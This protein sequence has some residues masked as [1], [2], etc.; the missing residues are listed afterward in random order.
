MARINF[1][2]NTHLLGTSRMATVG[3]TD[4]FVTTGGPIVSTDLG[5]VPGLR[6][7]R[8]IQAIEAF[9]STTSLG[10]GTWTMP[11]DFAHVHADV[12]R[13]SFYIY[14]NTAG[15]P[16]FQ[17]TKRN[18]NGSAFTTIG[19]TSTQDVGG[20]YSATGTWVRVSQLIYVDGS[21]TL[22]NNSIRVIPLMEYGANVA[23]GTIVRVAG[24]QIERV[25]T[26]YVNLDLADPEPGPYFSVF[27]PAT[28]FE[29]YDNGAAKGGGNIHQNPLLHD[30][31]VT[32]AANGGATYTTSFVDDGT[33]G[34]ATTL[35]YQQLVLTARSGV[36]EIT[37]KAEVSTSDNPKVTAGRAYIFSAYAYSSQT[38]NVAIR[39]VWYN[40][41]G[42]QVAT[43]SWTGFSLTANTWQRAGVVTTAPSTATRVNMHIAFPS[44]ADNSLPATMRVGGYKIEEGSLADASSPMQSFTR[45]PRA[46][47]LLSA[48]NSGVG[49]PTDEVITADN[50]RN[51]GRPFDDIIS[52]SF[53][54]QSYPR[55]SYVSPAYP[56]GSTQ[57]IKFGGNSRVVWR[58]V[59]WEQVFVY[60]R[61]MIPSV[62]SGQEID[63]V[64][65]ISHDAVP[66]Q[67]LRVSITGDGHLRVFGLND[68]Q[69]Y[70]GSSANPVQSGAWYDLYIQAM[71]DKDPTTVTVSIS[72]P[73]SNATYEQFVP[74]V[75]GE[76]PT[77]AASSSITRIGH[78]ALG[79]YYN[80]ASVK[81]FYLA[82]MSARGDV[83]DTDFG[84][85]PSISRTTGSLEVA[86]RDEG[87]D[88]TT[89][90]KLSLVSLR[91]PDL[92]VEA[93]PANVVLPTITGHALLTVVFTGEM[94]ESTGG[95]PDDFTITLNGGGITPV[96]WSDASYMYD[97]PPGYPGQG[98]HDP[99][100]E[101]GGNQWSTY[102]DQV[103]M[104]RLA[105]LVSSAN[106]GQTL[107]ITRTDSGIT[108]VNVQVAI[109]H[110][111]ANGAVL[112]YDNFP[113]VTVYHGKPVTFPIERNQGIYTPLAQGKYG[114]VEM[115]HLLVDGRKDWDYPDPVVLSPNPA[116]EP[117]GMVPRSTITGDA[118]A[119]GTEFYEA[120]TTNAFADSYVMT[121]AYATTRGVYN[122]GGDDDWRAPFP[123]SV[124]WFSRGILWWSVWTLAVPVSGFAQANL[125]A[126]VSMT[127]LAKGYQA[128]FPNLHLSVGLYGG[129]GQTI[130]R[131]GDIGPTVGLTGRVEVK[132]TGSIAPTIGLTGERAI[133][134]P[135][136]LYT[137]PTG[138]LH[139]DGVLPVDVV[140]MGT[141]PFVTMTGAIG[142]SVG[143]V[144][145]V[146]EPLYPPDP[147]RLTLEPI[148]DYLTL[149]PIDPMTGNTL[150]P[151]GEPLTFEPLIDWRQ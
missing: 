86:V 30:G 33:T 135:L 78:V 88:T 84:V 146:P 79:N 53:N 149:E 22:E 64:T 34:P 60:T 106:S 68:V 136:Y 126:T 29:S 129:V 139:L 104:L 81:E 46:V 93:S 144:G 6:G 57:P 141:V 116:Q 61:F 123:D 7:Y 54:G 65:L 85:L 25:P 69:H 98:S 17:V 21:D 130:S 26:G 32:W 48:F 72:D 52:N 15:Q 10:V 19:F 66:Y 99:T 47:D 16:R 1:A 109:V 97:Y 13:F 20:F 151:I 92:T 133:Q 8:H 80:T 59:G 103:G 145:K 42:A 148:V 11:W 143:L 128:Y 51:S 113:D 137:G 44:V 83:L 95:V 142:H 70:I 24:M 39:L 121:R 108:G 40:D 31:L 76:V 43:Q 71:A 132:L 3:E 27:T 91:G 112:A 127:G 9:T 124:P 100:T 110:G 73:A 125:A 82:E 94:F 102:G 12:Y 23:N 28:T 140:A 58:S 101:G 49:A 63:L 75:D 62:G 77:V 18:W 74:W 114:L 45:L 14:S 35:P 150:E 87:T 131:S 55:W 105:Y 118:T 41:A 90:A 147:D 38:E 107:A 122:P 117:Y 138:T 50:S 89:A 119:Q 37:C 120:E 134:L 56:A 36:T 67:Q 111:L 115:A 2:V 4:K 5:G 96:A